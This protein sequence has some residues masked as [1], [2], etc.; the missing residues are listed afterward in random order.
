PL[1]M[2]LTIE[3]LRS[4]VVLAEHLHFGRAAAALYVSQPALTKQIRKI[5]NTLGGPL[6]LRKPRQLT[7]TRAGKV[8]VEHARSLLRDPQLALDA[9]RSAMPA[10]AGLL[11]IGVGLSSLAI[12]TP[13]I[14]QQFRARFPRVNISMRELSTPSQLEE[15]ENHTLDI[16]FARL[17]V[18]A[19]AISVVSLFSDRLV[20]AVCPGAAKKVP[21]GL[22]SLALEPFVLVAR[23][24]SASLLGDILPSCS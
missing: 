15:L 21:G 22:R 16:G 10:E 5:E 3:Q 11:P 7:L 4:V 6:F 9:S 13:K 12:G 1:V 18:S 24:A 20:L 19:V 14:I 17:P 23:S 8:L 2:D